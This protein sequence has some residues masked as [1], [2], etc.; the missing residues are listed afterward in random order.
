MSE[1]E[2][3][4][5]WPVAKCAFR[6]A[7]AEEVAEYRNWLLTSSPG[8]VAVFPDLRGIAEADWPLYLGHIIPLGV[9]KNRRPKPEA[10]EFAVRALVECEKTPFHEVALKVARAV[11][12]TVRADKYDSG[13]HSGDPVWAWRML[14]DQLR[15]IS[16]GKDFV[17][18][19]EYSWPQS[20]AQYAGALGAYLVPGEDN[21]PQLAL[22]PANLR[23]ALILHAAR[24]RATG[25]T[26]NICDYCRAPFLSGGSRGRNKRGDSRFCSDECRWK[27]H[28]ESRRKAR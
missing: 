5:E 4:F 22:R 6:P 9:A 21:K 13:D 2:I 19:K 14:A 12:T 18:G 23:D 1:F 3:D 16:R 15:L 8:T 27:F 20:E 17:R 10:M 24:M 25:T 7:T 11:G 28:N 26:F